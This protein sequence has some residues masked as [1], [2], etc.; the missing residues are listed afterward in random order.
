MSIVINS[1]MRPYLLYY[2]VFTPRHKFVIEKHEGKRFDY[3]RHRALSD[4]RIVIARCVLVKSANQYLYH[5]E[6]IPLR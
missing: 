3:W 6:R 1:V 2:K 5:Y 4:D